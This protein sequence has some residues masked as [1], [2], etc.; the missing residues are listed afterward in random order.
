MNKGLRR[1]LIPPYEAVTR[2][3]NRYLLNRFIPFLPSWTLRKFYYR[4]CG[5]SFGKHSFIDQNVYILNPRG[6][7]LGDYVHINQGCFLDARAKEGIIIGNNVS[8]SHYAKLITGGHD[9]NSPTFAGVFKPIHIQDYVWI[10]V[11]SIIMQGVDIAEGCVIATGAVVTK[12]T[13]PYGLYIGCPAKKV[14]DRIKNLVYHPLA[15]EN[16]FRYF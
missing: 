15:G 8:I 16:H 7:K 5:V 14:K 3:F 12:D 13:T 2:F 11:S 9:W 1:L 6:L 4:L 10:G